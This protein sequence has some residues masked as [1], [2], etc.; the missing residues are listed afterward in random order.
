MGSDAIGVDRISRTVGYKIKRG[1]FQTSSP[2]LPQRIAIFGEANVANQADLSTDPIEITSAKQAGELFGYGSPIHGQMRILRPISGE[3]V[4]GI[5]TVVYAQ[6][7]APGAAAKKIEVEVSGVAT[8][9]GTHYIL[10]AGRD[11][12]DGELYAINIEEGDTAADIHAKIEDAINNVLGSPMSATSTQYEATLTSKWKGLTANALTA[13]VEVG[14]SDLGLDYVF[15]STQAGSGT[16]DIAASLALFGNVW[17]TI[18]LNSYGTVSAVMNALEAFNGIPLDLNPTGRYQGT[19]W[20]PFIALTGSVAD[21]PSATTDARKAEVTIAICPAP[22]SAGLQYEAAA[23]A[24][25]LF[26]PTAQ[27]NPHL[28]I[29][30]Q[31]YPDMPTP[32][33]I[34]S[35]ADYNNRDLFVKKGCS[36]VDLVNDKYQ[37]QDF[38]TTYH[39]V[40]EVPPQ[41]RY[42][43]DLMLDFNVRYGYLL[44]ELIN[45]LDHAI[46]NDDDIVT[47]SNVVKPKQWKACL[48]DYAEDMEKRALIV[49]SDFMVDNTTV[50]INSSNPNRFDTTFKYKR[51]GV[52]RQSATTAEAGFNFGT[53]TA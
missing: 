22:G 9:N 8:G 19:A 43:R 51:S 26:A 12:V 38:V 44:L 28:D 36:T 33:S 21:D 2:N 23:N 35:M 4:G 6:E 40:G 50:V 7:E 16:P 20:K 10:I 34:G 41:F 45:V 15:S 49:D 39:P 32:D 42:C 47:A 5:P 25:V 17:N 13:S 52:V 46:A 37:V 31:S 14:D 30:G 48:A 53:L 1:N 18:V 11:G 29:G 24:C 3:G 27:N